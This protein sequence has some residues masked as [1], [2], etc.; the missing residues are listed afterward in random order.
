MESGLIG[1]DMIVGFS[2]SN[3]IKS[4][5]GYWMFAMDGTVKFEDDF[6]SMD[7]ENKVWLWNLPYGFLIL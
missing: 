4:L 3:F 6:G 2:C 1:I 7:C 5:R